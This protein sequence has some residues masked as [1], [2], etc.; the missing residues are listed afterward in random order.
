MA[1]KLLVTLRTPFAIVQSGQLRQLQVFVATR[2]ES[3]DAD[4]R[5]DLMVFRTSKVFVPG[6]APARAGRSAGGP[7][8]VSDGIGMFIT[9]TTPTDN[10][11]AMVPWPEEKKP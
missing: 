5:H 7:T 10:V 1:D 9:I 11:S 4:S 6:N 2:D 8:L 3:M